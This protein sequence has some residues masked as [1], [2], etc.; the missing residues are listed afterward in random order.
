MNLVSKSLLGMLIV[1]WGLTPSCSLTPAQ[2]RT[3]D[4][5]VST[6]FPSDEWQGSAPE[7]QG[8][9]STLILQM[10]HEIRDENIEIHSFLLVRNGFLVTE[11]Y[12]DPYS[13]NI[14]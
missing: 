14:K 7:E 6:Y 13:R 8:L 11:A 12:F 4:V 5:P 1:L 9:D 3:T 10:F 2:Q